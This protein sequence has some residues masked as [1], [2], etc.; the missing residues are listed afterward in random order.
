MSYLIRPSAPGSRTVGACKAWSNTA[1]CWARFSTGT[2]KPDMW[3]IFNR[4]R[5]KTARKYES[6]LEPDPQPPE[7]LSLFLEPGAGLASYVMTGLT[8]YYKFRFVWFSEANTS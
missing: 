5:P 3:Q 7:D 4:T 6:V 1:Q 8:Q 2:Q